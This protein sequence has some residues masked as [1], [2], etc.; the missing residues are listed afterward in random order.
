MADCRRSADGQRVPREIAEACWGR[1]LGSAFITDGR[2]VLREVAAACWER[3]LRS[4]LIQVADFR[5]T[6]GSWEVWLR[7]R[8]S[9]LLRNEWCPIELALRHNNRVSMHGWNLR[10][11]N[12][13]APFKAVSMI[14][15][16]DKWTALWAINHML[17]LLRLN[18]TPVFTTI[19]DYKAA[20]DHTTLP[21]SLYLETPLITLVLD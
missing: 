14:A 6:K 19:S 10:R 7:S 16:F 21:H 4:S 11:Q 12:H 15:C 8:T 13:N 3:G 17:V 1:G 5:R 20:P 18:G 2:R 9:V